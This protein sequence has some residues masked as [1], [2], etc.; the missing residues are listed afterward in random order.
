M[1]F[2]LGFLP[3][4]L[5]WIL[6]GNIDFRLAICIALA[7]A[8]A[9]QVIT[10]LRKQPWRSLDVG[11]LLIFVLLALVSFVV[12]D[13]VLE[14]WL[15]PLS[16]LGLFLVALVGIGIGRP[17]VR[18]YA[19]ASVDAE[20]ARGDGFRYITTGMTWLW[21]MV[22]GLMTLVSTIPP[23]VDGNAS[24]QD[25]D[26]LLSIMCY[27]VLP[28]VLLGIAGLVSAVFPRWFDKRSSMIDK[29]EADEAPVVAP[30]PAAPADLSEGPLAVSVP[31][32]S[33]HHEPFALAVS[34]APPGAS[35]EI[36]ATGPD[37]FGGTWKSAAS[38]AASS[39]GS[40]DVATASPRS[41]DWSS[42]DAGAPLW[43]M[44]FAS[45][46][47]T[48]DLFVPP[49]EGWPVTVD[50]EVA[51]V[52][53]VQRTVQRRSATTA[54]APEPI[55]IDGRPGLLVRPGG[56]APATGWP[57]VVCFGG[58]EGG[59]ES[60]AGNAVLLAAHGYLALAACWLP[61]PEAATG[62]ASVPLEHFLAPLDLL[63]A[64]SDVDPTRV[65]ALAVSR[66]SEGVLAAATRRPDRGYARLV[67][68]S[69]SSVT[70][71]ALG[72]D[73]SIPDT[74]SWT[75]GGEPLP[76]L[77]LPTGAIMPQLLRNAWQIGRDTAAHRPTLLRLRPSYEAG[78]H[79]RSTHPVDAA[80]PAE[81][82]TG[83]L[84]VITGGD[85]QVWPSEQM[86][87]GLSGRR[88]GAGD[89]H[90]HFPEAGHLIRFGQLPTDAQWTGGIALGGTRTGQAEAQRVATPKVL[91]FLAAMTS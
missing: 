83:P 12:D 67:L 44:R 17:F 89:D 4:I 76:W 57:A 36:S 56:P 9:G 42:A 85:D 50:V 66:G 14:L 87:G 1:G 21:V 51:G 6:V 77:P 3:W 71:Q 78:L 13:A 64:R 40:V 34:G 63:L 20:T 43:A 15:Q 28:Y 25:E 46:G 33:A 68:T 18:E 60:Q 29:R 38:F 19:A 47:R 22:F 49:A 27:W 58:S 52:G 79:A 81:R 91:E 75:Y 26:S 90:L 72:P 82:V 24:N 48:P 59:Y 53:R 62:L 5:Y 80:I 31:K 70:W 65:A 10:R 41:G 32:E 73:G 8:V 55:E 39:S 54:V 37:L 35:V 74:A 23:L 45:P 86:A 30:I 2:V 11:S 7:V 16:N 88:S 61:E 84:L 69:P